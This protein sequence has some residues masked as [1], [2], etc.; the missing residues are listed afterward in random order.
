MNTHDEFLWGGLRTRL[1]GTGRVR[2]RT[3]RLD[4]VGQVPDR[5]H[6]QVFFHPVRPALRQHLQAAQPERA[7]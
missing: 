1:E 4:S 7:G 2:P 3:V 6:P 5:V